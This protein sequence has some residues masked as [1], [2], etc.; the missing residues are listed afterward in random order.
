MA[1]ITKVITVKFNRLDFIKH[2]TRDRHR[3]SLI[4]YITKIWIVTISIGCYCQGYSSE[5]YNSDI[6]QR[7]YCSMPC[8]I[9]E[10][11]GVI[12]HIGISIPTLRIGRVGAIVSGWIK[13]LR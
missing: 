4:C 9:I 6:E 3:N 11:D 2:L 5:K 12:N 10:I 8:W 7:D 13:R 1:I